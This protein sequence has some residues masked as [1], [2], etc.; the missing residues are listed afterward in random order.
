MLTPAPPCSLSPRGD[1][2]GGGGRG[3]GSREGFPSPPGAPSGQRGGGGA[4]PAGTGAGFQAGGGGSGS[5]AGA[6]GRRGAG[7]R[8][9]PGGQRWRGQLSPRS[10][11]SRPRGQAA[12][13]EGC[14]AVSHRCPAPTRAPHRQ[15]PQMLPQKLRAGRAGAA[16]SLWPGRPAR[17]LSSRPVRRDFVAGARRWGEWMTSQSKGAV[18]LFEDCV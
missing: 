7:P 6:R 18:T 3:G 9:A 14:V 11:R 5:G 1:A 4:A 15:P 17:A 10:P 2:G 12:G 16:G 13:K 8:G